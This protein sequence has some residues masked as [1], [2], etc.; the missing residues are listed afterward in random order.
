MLKS[1][2]RLVYDAQS[3]ANDEEELVCTRI[4]GYLLLH[5]I[6]LPA[7]GTILQE[8]ASIRNLHK[9]QVFSKIF[10]LGKMYMDHLIRPCEFLRISLSAHR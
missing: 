9:K 7:R 4:V 5:P 1:L 3:H 6:S 2:Y 10:E 8:L